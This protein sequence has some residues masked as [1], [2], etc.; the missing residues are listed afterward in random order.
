MADVEIT[1]RNNG[2]YS[3]TGPIRLLDADGKAVDISGRE[4]VSL[5]RCGGSSRKP[6][7]DGTHGKI[8]FQG[9]LAATE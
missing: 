6:F 5:C 1:I 8:G 9:D 7:C 2:P 3:V 4:R